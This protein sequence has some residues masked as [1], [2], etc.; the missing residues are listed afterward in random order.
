MRTKITLAAK[1]WWEVERNLKTRSIKIMPWLWVC[2]ENAIQCNTNNC[3]KSRYN[4]QN[5]IENRHIEHIC[6]TH[7]MPNCWKGCWGEWSLLTGSLWNMLGKPWPLLPRMAVEELLQ[8]WETCPNQPQSMNLVSLLRFSERFM[9]AKCVL[10]SA[11]FPS[12]ELQYHETKTNQLR[13]SHHMKTAGKR[14]SLLT[15]GPGDNNRLN[16]Q[17]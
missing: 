4:Q 10:I 8:F 16:F 15:P 14:W 17:T 5:A 2:R 11:R 6:V 3:R 13:R 9:T 12:R 7:T 1:I